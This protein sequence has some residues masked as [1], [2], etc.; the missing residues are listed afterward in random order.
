[1]WL[2]HDLVYYYGRGQREFH[3]AFTE[4]SEKN[5]GSCPSRDTPTNSH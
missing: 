3:L 4:F 2:D 1:M 5:Q